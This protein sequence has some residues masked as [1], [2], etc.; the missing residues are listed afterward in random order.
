MAAKERDQENSQ[1]VISLAFYAIFALQC[2][3]AKCA[4]A[5][6]KLVVANKRFSAFKWISAFE[7]NYKVHQFIILS[8]VHTH[9]KKKQRN[10][11]AF[12]SLLFCSS[13]NANSNSFSNLRAGFFLFLVR[14]S[15]TVREWRRRQR[16]SQ[17]SFTVGVYRPKMG[18]QQVKIITRKLEAQLFDRECEKKQ[19][20]RERKKQVTM[21]WQMLD[22]VLSNVLMIGTRMLFAAAVDALFFHH[23]SACVVFSCVFCFTLIS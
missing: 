10:E 5:T 16:G 3:L 22:D 2:H 4:Q 23:T 13:Q 6:D 1:S 7:T 8:A 15:I 12:E 19:R 18:R 14:D 17:C 20:K 21:Y 9:Y 11:T